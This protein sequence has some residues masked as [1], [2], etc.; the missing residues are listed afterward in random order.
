MGNDAAINDFRLL[1]KPC[2]VT[3][4]RLSTGEILVSSQDTDA[5]K[6]LKIEQIIIAA[7]NDM[8]VSITRT[9]QDDIIIRVTRNFQFSTNSDP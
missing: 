2:S 3:W 9:L 5:T 6:L 4:M 1:A 7:Y 8:G